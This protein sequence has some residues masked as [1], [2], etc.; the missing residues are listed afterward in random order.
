MLSS[1]DAA[2]AA[3]ADSHRP[4]AVRLQPAARLVSLPATILVQL[5]AAPRWR[6][7]S[8]LT[9]QHPVPSSSV[10]YSIFAVVFS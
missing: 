3:A 2:A 9:V 1:V 4:A 10:L 8:R 5:A 7:T 6:R